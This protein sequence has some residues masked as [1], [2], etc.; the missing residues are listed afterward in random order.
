MI[1]GKDY[2]HD[3]DPT[4]GGVAIVVNS[5]SGSADTDLDALVSRIRNNGSDVVSVESVEDPSTL[6]DHVRRAAAQADTVVIGG[7]DGTISRSLAIIKETGRTLGVLPLGTANDFARSLGIPLNPGDAADIIHLGARRSI[8]LGE[9][10]GQLFCNSVSIG[11]PVEVA[12]SH[13]RSWKKLLG[14]FSCPIAWTKAVV[15]FRSFDVV[16]RND[17]RESALGSLFALTVMNGRY[18]GGGLTVD[19]EAQIDDGLLKIYSI[20]AVSKWKLIGYFLSLKIGKLLRDRHTNVLRAG[21]VEISARKPKP[22]NIDGDI[23]EKTP[24]SVRV[25]PGAINVI[26]PPG[27]DRPSA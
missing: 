23:R 16:L 12:A 18:H 3:P 5:L 2:G 6:G 4:I 7:G 1:A 15:R 25:I 8:D 13:Q 9:V 26:V 22:I 20:E 10:N 11:F 17:G 24:A 14:I 27:D 21:S 19:Q